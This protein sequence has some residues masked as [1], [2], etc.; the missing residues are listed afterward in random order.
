MGLPGVHVNHPS[1]D[2]AVGDVAAG[3]FEGQRLK[4]QHI[5]VRHLAHPYDPALDANLT[6]S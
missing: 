4:P 5:F 1:T 2:V 6:V 3:Y